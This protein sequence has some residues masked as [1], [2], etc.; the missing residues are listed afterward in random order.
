MDTQFKDIWDEIAKEISKE[1]LLDIIAL[2]LQT[3]DIEEAVKDFVYE[4]YSEMEEEM[5]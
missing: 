4:Y 3:G 5:M 1:E 2:A